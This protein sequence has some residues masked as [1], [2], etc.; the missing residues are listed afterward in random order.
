[1]TRTSKQRAAAY[2]DFVKSAAAGARMTPVTK[3]P[4]TNIGIPKTPGSSSPPGRPTPNQDSEA[5]ARKEALKRRLKRTAAAMKAK[6]K[7]KG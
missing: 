2:G 1:M 6:S 4:G 7:K 5:E 3:T